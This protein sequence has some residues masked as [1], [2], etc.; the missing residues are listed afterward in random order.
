[1]DLNVAKA[2]RLGP[3]V[4]KKDRPLLMT[5]EDVDDKAHM[6]SHSYFLKHHEQY[7]KVYLVPDKTRL[8][9][10]KHKRVVDELKQRKANRE[11]NMIIRNGVISQRQPRV[12]KTAEATN[13]Q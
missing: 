10:T 8:E 1:L 2:I 12:S 6:L 11:T 4:S 3:K 7:N 13:T 5:V 9:P